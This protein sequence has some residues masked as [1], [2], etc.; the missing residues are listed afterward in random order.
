MGAARPH[1][2]RLVLNWVAAIAGLF[3]FVV[4]AIY[5]RY[6]ADQGVRRGGAPA[7]SVPHT[8]TRPAALAHRES[9][10]LDHGGIHVHAVVYGVPTEAWRPI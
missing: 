8:R 3:F 9:V 10:S 7:R 6:F 1:P 5:V 2:H 4:H